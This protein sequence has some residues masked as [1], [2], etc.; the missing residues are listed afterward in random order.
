MFSSIRHYIFRIYNI[1]LH[2]DE[3]M[4]LLPSK[5]PTLSKKEHR[6]QPF[7]DYLVECMKATSWW[8]FC[9]GMQQGILWDELTTAVNWL[10]FP[11]QFKESQISDR[12]LFFL[13]E[14]SVCH[15]CLYGFWEARLMTSWENGHKI[16]PKTNWI[17]S[18]VSSIRLGVWKSRAAS[19]SCYMN[20]KL[21][22]FC[23]KVLCSSLSFPPLYTVSHFHT[24]PN[25]LEV[26]RDWWRVL[27]TYISGIV[28]YFGN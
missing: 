26:F 14:Q 10:Q 13:Y 19:L 4:N 22:V 3:H 20:W 17:I 15:V 6:V 25:I 23:S 7:M 9:W 11:C 8:Q 28:F 5:E 2:Y 24:G 12:K 16:R 27:Q 1:F 18:R 21:S